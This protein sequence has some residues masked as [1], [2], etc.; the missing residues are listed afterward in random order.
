MSRAPT[1][2]EL[3]ILQ[4]LAELW[5]EGPRHWVEQV[6]VQPLADAGMGS[7]R[8]LLRSDADPTQVF[9]RRA[10][11][12]EFTDADGVKVI[13]SLN[14]DQHGVPFELDV[15]KVDFTATNKLKDSGAGDL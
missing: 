6:R 3:Q 2:P 4:R 8:L 5:T 15:W 13:A 9:G 14:L 1:K 12:C 11:E 10:A 7:L